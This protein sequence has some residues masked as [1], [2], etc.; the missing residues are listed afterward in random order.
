ME[1]ALQ[2][3]TTIIEQLQQSLMTS[4][5]QRQ[6]QHQAFFQ[7]VQQDAYCLSTLLQGAEC[8]MR[9]QIASEALDAFQQF[10]V[11]RSLHRKATDRAGD[12][13]RSYALACSI[14]K[15]PL[16]ESC[17]REIIAREELSGRHNIAL[18]V[19]TQHYAAL[20]DRWAASS[21]MEKRHQQAASKSFSTARRLMEES[22]KSSNSLVQRMPPRFNDGGGVLRQETPERACPARAYQQ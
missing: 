2:R 7:Q 15:M 19:Q 8:R 12:A 18:L 5:Q 4:S 6:Q 21:I 22:E 13:R 10:G 3:S 9:Q 1:D 16:S 20:R 17:N 11:M 14:A